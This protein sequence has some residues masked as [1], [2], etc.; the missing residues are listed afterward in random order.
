MEMNNGREAYNNSFACVA[1]SNNRYNAWVGNVLGRSGYH[2]SGGGAF[3]DLNNTQNTTGFDGGIFCTGYAG[4]DRSSGTALNGFDTKVL[5]TAEIKDNYNYFDNGIHSTEAIGTDSI[6]NSWYYTSKPVWYGAGPWP[7]V[8]PGSPTTAVSSNLPAGARYF[9][10]LPAGGTAGYYTFN[11]NEQFLVKDWATGVSSSTPGITLSCWVKVA[12]AGITTA[13]AAPVIGVHSAFDAA[14]FGI[15]IGGTGGNTNKP[16]AYSVNN[17][18]SASGNAVGTTLLN[19]GQ[20]HL[21]TAEF[22]GTASRAIYVDGNATAQATD[23]TSVTPDPALEALVVALG[24]IPQKNNPDGY[25]GGPFSAAYPGVW[26]V[27]LT[28]T[29]ITN[30][31]TAAPS[32]V[33]ASALQSAPPFTGASPEPDTAT[34]PP[35]LAKGPSGGGAAPSYSSG[36]PLAPAPTPTPS[37]TNWYYYYD[38]YQHRHF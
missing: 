10:S 22:T 4:T 35:V 26:T 28:G 18:G 20:W 7:W 6:A 16:I 38:K 3:Y 5:T 37:N 11:G 34:N 32:T 14:S 2:A 30:L 23:T 8:D 31:K 12:A 21:L 25:T 36:G 17:A 15:E 9:A 1:E 19:D 33:H 29:E 27:A 24:E 13:N